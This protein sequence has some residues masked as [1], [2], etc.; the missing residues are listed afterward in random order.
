MTIV[1]HLILR[2]LHPHHK[3]D[4]Y[5]E[6]GNVKK[7]MLAQYDND[8]HGFC[9]ATNNKKLAIDMKDPTAYMV[10]SLVQDLFQAFK[11]DSPP[12]DFKS[13]FTLT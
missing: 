7:L 9:N 6:T 2:R 4:M 12:T 1:A 13:D 3:V 8:V 5:A 10:D 11:Y